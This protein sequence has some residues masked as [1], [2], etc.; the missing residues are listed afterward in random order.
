[1]VVST[2]VNPLEFGP[3]EDYQRYPRN[4]SGDAEFCEREKV[5][6]LFRPLR[7]ELFPTDYSIAV[8]ES[9]VSD[10][11]CGISRPHYFKGVCTFFTVMFNLIQPDHLVLGLRDAQKT[12]VLRKLVKEL[13]LPIEIHVVETVRDESGLVYNTRNAYLNDNQR[14]DAATMYKAL[15]EGKK[16]ADSGITNVDRILAEVTHHI[17]QIRRLRV[18]YVAAVDPDTMKPVRSEIVPDQTLIMAAAWC[19]EVRLIDNILL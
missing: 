1:M 11:L 7:K 2:L 13:Y 15:L 14:A 18:I 6:L 17:S 10:G 5:D 3:N 8:S 19:D 4:S 16:L 12:A 9:K